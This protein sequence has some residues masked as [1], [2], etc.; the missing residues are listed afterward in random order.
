LRPFVGKSGKKMDVGVGG[1]R[2][3]IFITNVRKCAPPEGKESDEEKAASIAH[4]VRAYLQPELDAIAAAHA[5]AGRKRAVVQVIGAD[6]TKLM[7]GRGNMQKY[8]GSVFNRGEWEAM[9]QVAEAVPRF[10]DIIEEAEATE[11]DIPF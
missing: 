11:Y 3:G 7:F 10:D 1:S 8:H 5:A 4:C 6:A 9:A 2:D